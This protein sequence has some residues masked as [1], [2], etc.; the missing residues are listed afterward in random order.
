MSLNTCC[1]F[2]AIALPIF[3]HIF[4]PYN[5]NIPFT[6]NIVE[7]TFSIFENV[8]IQPPW[9]CPTINITSPCE[10]Q[11]LNRLRFVFNLTKYIPLWGLGIQS[12]T[13]YVNEEGGMY[14]SKVKV[15]LPIVLYESTFYSTTTTRKKR[16]LLLWFHYG[17]Y[18]VGNAQDGLILQLSKL[19][20][21]KD[22]NF[23]FQFEIKMFDIEYHAFTKTPPS[24]F[25]KEPWES[26]RTHKNPHTRVGIHSNSTGFG[27]VKTGQT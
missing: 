24:E 23:L 25:Q 19:I 21:Q 20:L 8:Y 16:K 22:R 27:G 10:Q 26:A 1:I 11:A 3:A 9:R 14:N 6:N 17:G 13:I 5:S 2:V 15:S 7:L 12:K 18:V 4:I